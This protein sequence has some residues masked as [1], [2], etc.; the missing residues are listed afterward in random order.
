MG[1]LFEELEAREAAARV[2]VGELEAE[3]AELSGRLRLAKES[4]GR[5]QLGAVRFGGRG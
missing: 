5:L 2:R 1:S 4:L 3:V